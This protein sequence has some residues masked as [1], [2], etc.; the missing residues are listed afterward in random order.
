[1]PATLN[2][3]VPPKISRTG[4]ARPW[5]MM[6]AIGVLAALCIAAYI[7]L[8]YGSIST[9]DAQID[10]HLVPVSPKVSGYISELLVNDNQLVKKGQVI[11][12]IDSRHANV[13]L[14]QADAA[15]QNAKSQAEASSVD[16]PL[17]NNTT[18]S[19]IVAAEANLAAA[20]A[21][22]TQA[23]STADKAHHADTSYAMANVADRKANYERAHADLARMEPLAEKRMISRLQY[24]QYV[25]AERMAKSQLDAAQQ[26]LSAQSDTA[27][28][29]DAG[30]QIAASRVGQAKAQLLEAKANHMRTGIR[31][32]DAEAMQAA[33]K[34]AQANLEKA[35]L[36]LAYTEIVAPQEGKVTRRTVEMGAY[37]SPGQTLLT[38][39]PIRDIWVTA[40]FKETQLHSLRP[41]N[42]A[43]ITVDQLGRTFAGRVDSIANATGSR[44]SLLPPENATGNYVKI[45]QRIPVK[46]V[47][48]PGAL[49]SGTLDVGAS[50]DVTVHTR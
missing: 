25:A 34:M 4:F 29:D 40:N 17:T 44:L 27:D 28:I 12:R 48:D 41:G 39:V 42:H 36:Q 16:V 11:A 31:S 2:E 13:S 15:L 43:E 7:V 30:V 21:E 35:R 6:L 47:L 1:M 23:R 32:H 26:S 8:T 14:E 18:D 24:D 10:G 50:A 45:V 19:S 46:I 3:T 38:L 20:E 5:V 33:V 37:V 9:D 22:L 49:S